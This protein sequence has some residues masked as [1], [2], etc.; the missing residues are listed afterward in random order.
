ME[1]HALMES[2]GSQSI[3]AYAHLVTPACVP[4]IL[5]ERYDTYGQDHYCQIMNTRTKLPP[6]VQ[7]FAP[8]AI[9]RIPIGQLLFRS[10][11][12]H[13]AQGDGAEVHQESIDTFAW[14]K[15]SA[16]RSTWQAHFAN[17]NI[18]VNFPRSSAFDVA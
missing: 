16:D 5:F 12:W 8:R 2:R 4:T 17:Q 13:R 10:G 3:E 9:M 14:P 6:G 1:H 7:V 15:R 18:T 11:R